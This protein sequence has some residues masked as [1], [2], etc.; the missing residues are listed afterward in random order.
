MSSS[1]FKIS[2]RSSFYNLRS[3][4]AQRIYDGRRALS[5]AKTRLMD[6]F[7]VSL[8]YPVASGNDGAFNDR[9]GP[10]CASFTNLRTMLFC[11]SFP[12][13]SHNEKT[14]LAEYSHLMLGLIKP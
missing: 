11:P 4:T 12:L 3:Y 7:Q 9:L 2:C 10:S 5:T 13:V 1:D 14:K 6:Y 8:V